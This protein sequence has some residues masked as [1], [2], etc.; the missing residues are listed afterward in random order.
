MGNGAKIALA[1]SLVL[2]LFL[3][4]AGVSAFVFRERLLHDLHGLRPPTP[5]NVAARA[6]DPDVRAKLRDAMR[7]AA[8]TA[9][10]DF[11]A[12]REARMK[13]AELA[14]AP[15]YDRA[16]VKAEL[17]EARNSETHGRGLLDDRLLD[18]MG[19][20][21]PDQRAKLAEALKGRPPRHDRHGLDGQKGAPPP[22]K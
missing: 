7:S 15:T 14:A 9:K 2:N 19:T 10:P 17:V 3:I 18:F 12:A 6:L 16:A 22:S 20:L 21:P 4:G 8:L 1:I 11:V 5:L 13:A